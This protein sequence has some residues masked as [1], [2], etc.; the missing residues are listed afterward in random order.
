MNT[1]FLFPTSEKSIFMKYVKNFGD[2]CIFYVI[3]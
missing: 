1:H 2:F 3:V